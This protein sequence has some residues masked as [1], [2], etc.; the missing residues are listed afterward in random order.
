MK[1]HFKAVIFCRGPRAQRG[2]CALTL[3]ALLAA[4]VTGCGDRGRPTLVEPDPVGGPTLLR[5][6]TESQYR[7]T[8]AD[9]FGADVPVVAR[10]ERALRSEG[11]IAVGTGEAGISAFSI[12]QYDAAAQGVADA[13]LGEGQRE[14][15]LPCRPR[16]ATEFDA[17]CAGAFIGQYGPLLHR[18]PLTDEQARRYL[19]AARLGTEKLG[20]FYEGLKYALV[21]MMTSPQ[22]LL[23]IEQAQPDPQRPGLLQL[24]PY[25][26]AARLSYF[27]T[28]STPDRELLRAAGAGELDTG[29]GL[30]RQVDR[31][32]A[33]PRFEGALRAFFGDML[34]FDLFDDLAKDSEIYP[35]FNS[36]VAADAKEQTLR[37]IVY[38]LV[39]GHGDYRDL[40]TLE[41]TFM[42][43]PLGIIYRQPVPARHGWERVALSHDGS[44]LGIQSHVS[45]LALHAHPGRSSPT[46]RGKAI[47]NVFLCQQVPDPPANVDFSVVQD[48]SNT[49]M[50]TARDRLGAHN[51]EP[52]CSGC[53]RVMDPVGLALEN[54]DGLGHFRAREN[55]AVIDPSGFLDGTA[56][57]DAAGLATALR[58]HPETPRCAVERIYR[59]AVGRDTVWDERAYMDYLIAA[60]AESDYRVPDLMRTIALSDNFMAIAPPAPAPAGPELAHNQSD[61]RKPS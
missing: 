5:R 42:T 47:R 54:Y 20:D 25:S 9:I 29:S 59:F 16:S 57:E 37:D 23:R 61:G 40:F 36:D 1:S 22:F 13:I 56:Y 10:F 52:A 27:L 6:L 24:D 30:A 43:R 3:C 41:E 21:G 26:K 17:P 11:L 55:D 53:H 7:A 34:E 15:F 35:A 32:I 46:L 45:F 51:T 39:N 18:R 19:E 58:N 44:R 60:F 2:L 33:S 50:P 31:L 4:A 8:V 14:K 49:N 48:P 28:D 12:E 38:H